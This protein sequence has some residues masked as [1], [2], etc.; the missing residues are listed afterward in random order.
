MLVDKYVIDKEG[1]YVEY[2]LYDEDSKEVQHYKL[3]DDESLVPMIDLTLFIK[4]KWDGKEWIETANKAEIN[5]KNNEQLENIKNIKLLEV[6]NSCKQAIELGFDLKLSNNKIKHFS[7]TETDQINITT[8]Y[9]A[10]LQG[11]SG[12]LYHADG[13]LCTLFSAEDIILLTTMATQ[14]KTY[15]TT[16]CNHL[17]YWIKREID[18]NIINDIVYGCNLPDDLQKNMD[19]ILTSPMSNNENIDSGYI[20]T[21]EW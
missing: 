4:P 14:F 18:I 20:P 15:Q 13:E 17:R 7:L 8:A 6:N 16:Y 9:S 12:F 19:V 21:K 5:I 3:K 1:N 10:I 11:A 2:V